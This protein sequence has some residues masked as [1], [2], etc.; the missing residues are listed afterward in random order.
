M[1]EVRAGVPTF[2]QV[3]ER[4][5]ATL[6]EIEAL[7]PSAVTPDSRLGEDLGLDS[8]AQ[9]ELAMALEEV[10]DVTLDDDVASRIHTVREA[11]EA[12]CAAFPK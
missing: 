9:V 8:L 6:V 1:T 7:E 10:Y 4:V 2:E 5:R 12:V 11:A 3:L